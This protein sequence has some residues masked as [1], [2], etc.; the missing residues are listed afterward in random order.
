MISKNLVVT[1]SLLLLVFHALP[2][3][4]S[5]TS[6]A[7]AA[8]D[9]PTFIGEV[10][11]PLAFGLLMTAIEQKE[12]RTEKSATF[13]IASGKYA[14]VSNGAPLFVEKNDTWVPLSA[15]GRVEDGQFIFDRLAGGV[16]VRF[17]L[18]RPQYA[19]TQGG[20]GFA[21]A[22]DADAVGTIESGN[23]ISYRLNDGA[24][25]RW[26]VEGNLVRKD[27]T[28]EREGAAK[29]LSFSLWPSDHL[30]LSLRDDVF[31]LSDETSGEAI[32]V[33]QEPFLKTITGHEIDRDVSITENADGGYFYAYDET[34]LSFPY[35]LDPSS[36][37]RSGS[38]FVNEVYG[39]RVWNN[40]GNAAASDN[41]YATPSDLTELTDY[42]KATDFGFSISAGA[43]IDGI[44]AE[45]EKKDDCTDVHDTVVQL[46]KGG[47]ITGNNK[48]SG[49]V[50]SATDT[51]TTY[52]GSSDLWGLTFSTTDINATTF[53]MAFV[54][55]PQA[56]NITVDHMRI[57][58]YYTAPVTPVP[59]L[60]WWSVLLIASIIP[61][62]F[63]LP[64]K[65]HNAP[66]T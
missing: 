51:Y 17:D 28:I 50:W 33:T 47:T 53:G 60:P 44:V 37:P 56:C 49:A 12:E 64:R 19:L 22:F 25:L 65:F 46:V 4:H 59:D 34:G 48:A 16:E 5:L 21:M 52:G 24:V 45:I 41:A 61:F 62:A 39:D 58:V 11:N 23:V 1:G 42:L 9:Q 10:L 27:I 43:T 63:R 57:T 30:T 13:E 14:T 66:R 38:T 29:D 6:P 31:T 40:P 3:K 18:V 54:A 26:T 36:G 55:A 32:F 8:E 35:I 20:H 7:T 2:A 15:E